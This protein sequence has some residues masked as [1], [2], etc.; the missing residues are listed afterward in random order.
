MHLTHIF[1]QIVEAL[2]F[3]MQ[4]LLVRL[5]SKDWVLLCESLNNVRQIAIY[6][7]EKLL[8]IL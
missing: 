4:T 7:K 3:F 2:I 1:Q 5:E 6:H 8:D